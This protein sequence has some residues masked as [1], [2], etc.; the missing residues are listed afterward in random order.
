[1]TTQ[2]HR[3]G[4]YLLAAGLA[5]GLTKTEAARYAG[6]P[7]RTARRRYQDP[8]FQALVEKIRNRYLTT[9]LNELGA[10][11]TIVFN[12]LRALLDDPTTPPQVRHAAIRTHLEYTLRYTQANTLTPLTSLD[13][14]DVD[15]PDDDLTIIELAET[16]WTEIGRAKASRAELEAPSHEDLLDIP[17]DDSSDT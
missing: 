7:L 12:A 14:D 4:D 8:E 2:P 9:I 5:A 3:R 11:T 17:D 15:D 13:A 16:V 6:M 10:T 1:M